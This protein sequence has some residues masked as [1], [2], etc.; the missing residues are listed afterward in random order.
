MH[1]K[2]LRFAVSL[3]AVSLLTGC[4]G[5]QAQ[6]HPST[7]P[8]P[9][10]LLEAAAQASQAR[11]VYADIQARMHGT[12]VEQVRLDEP[13]A[14]V[15]DFMRARVRLDYNGPM[16]EVIERVANDIGYRVNEYSKPSAGVGWSPWMRARGDKPLIDHIREMNT[17]VPWHIILDHRNRR[18]V[19]D[20]SVEGGMATQIR[21]ARKADERRSEQS[22]YQSS[23]PNTGALIQASQVGMQQGLTNTPAQPSSEAPAANPGNYSSPSY[24]GAAQEQQSWRVDIEGYQG[25]A[26]ARAMVAWLQED[27]LDATVIANGTSFDVRI[28]ANNNQDA[29]A[30]HDHLSSFDVPA[31]VGKVENNSRS[32]QSLPPVPRSPAASQYDSSAASASRS[33]QSWQSPSIDTNQSNTQ[34]AE[35]SILTGE[36]KQL[37]EGHYS[38]QAAY[39]KNLES[40]GRHIKSLAEKGIAAHLSPAGNGYNLRVG[41]FESEAEMRRALSNVRSNGFSDAYALSPRQ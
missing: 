1:P 3:A 17:Q 27:N 19:I 34:V 5:L 6:P 18:L 15:P 26:Q 39:G 37:F 23:M 14:G 11:M 20:Y 13:D 32:T 33:P 10:A 7:A 9:Q 31:V 36:Q 25:E 38:I 21:E 35:A 30:I 41:P 24:A 16:M 40:F 29:I 22:S 4:A 28:L 8:V 12:S 2:Q